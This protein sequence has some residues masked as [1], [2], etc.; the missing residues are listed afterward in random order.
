MNKKIFFKFFILPWFKWIA[1]I[2]YKKKYLVGKHFV[3]EPYEGWLWVLTGIWRQKILGF[4]RSIPFPC[5]FTARIYQHKNIFFHPDNLDNFQSPH[6][7]FDSVRAS[8]YMAEGVLIGP[9]V[10]LLTSNH[11]FNNFDLYQPGKDIVIG[12]NCWLGA[13]SV[14]LPGV[15]LGDH[16][17]VGAGAVV[18]KSFE[19]GSCVLAGVPA[20]IIKWL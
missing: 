10:K 15:T 19:Q 12:K 4:N 14:L 1:V 20:N 18:T 11:D 3:Q 9:G 8:I 17:I 13:Q 2:F 5:H 6:I 7:Y 16:T